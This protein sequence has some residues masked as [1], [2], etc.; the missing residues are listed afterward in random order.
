[1]R[2]MVTGANGFVGQHLIREL[3]SRGHE[4]IG[5]GYGGT[6]EPDVEAL[7]LTYHP[8]DLSNP[9]QVAE[10][11]LKGVDAVINL[12][13]LANV[14]ASFD[15]AEKYKHINVAM[16]SVL[17]ERILNIGLHARVVAVSTGAVYESDQ[18]MPLTESSQTIT[19]GSPYALSKLMME[20]AAH[21]LR[22]RGLDCVIARP[23][24]H[25]GPGQIPGFLIPDLYAKIIMSQ[26]TGQP[27]KVGNLNTKRDYTDVRDV[28]RAYADLSASETLEFDTYNVCSG[29]SRTGQEI[30]DLFLK[31]MKPEGR[32][33]V[34]VD[35]S[36]I[37]PND[38]LDLH[39]SHA[40]ITEETGWEPSIPF[41]QTIADFIAS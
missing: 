21:T 20:Q 25:A 6:P 5:V 24:N 17:S 15:D 12:A 7:L 38:P 23:F 33:Q 34:E 22:Q 3:K 16:L 28:V 14:G 31:Q 32:I 18:P 11:P 39:G 29:Q 19:S 26:K 4:V 27:I 8:C 36:L 2:T 30:F 41:E 1:M 40:R 9:A 35:Q 37:R 10:L 13:G